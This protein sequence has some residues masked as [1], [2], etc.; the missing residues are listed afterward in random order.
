MKSSRFL[1]VLA[2]VTV[3]AAVFVAC[4]VWAQEPGPVIEPSSPMHPSNLEGS[5]ASSQ[6][7]GLQSPALPARAVGAVAQ[8]ERSSAPLLPDGSPL[9]PASPAALVG[10][11][12]VDAPLAA[13][14]NLRIPGT[15]LKP[16]NSNATYVPTGG[17]GCFYST[18]SS[19]TS[20]NIGVFLPQ[21]S[22]VDTVRMYYYDTSATDS[23]AWFTV[24]D[25]YGN[26][27]QEWAVNS[28]GSSGNGFNDTALISHTVDYSLYSY[29]IN[30]RPYVL[31]AGMQ[32]CGFR[33]FYESP[34]RAVALPL[35]QRNH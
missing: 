7:P 3:L 33:I 16:R 11:E 5:T 31:G 25:L 17:G 29:A 18:A 12:S 6:P 9:S 19:Y 4:L 23:S 14:S 22:W 34:S 35:I 15:A 26:I 13:L 8:G 30:W 28:S 27:V 21:G 20:F 2:I 24:Y 1:G 32:N 10:A